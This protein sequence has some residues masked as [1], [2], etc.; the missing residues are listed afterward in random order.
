MKAEPE[1]KT[2][3]QIVCL[4]ENSRKQKGGSNMNASKTG[5]KGKPNEGVV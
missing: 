2:W 3:V 4:R 5:E 1:R